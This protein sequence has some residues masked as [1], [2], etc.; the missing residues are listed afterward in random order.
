MKTKFKV[1]ILT[2]VF[3]LN[4]FIVN[5]CRELKVNRQTNTNQNRKTTAQKVSDKNS[6]HLDSKNSSKN[7]RSKLKI[8]AIKLRTKLKKE[9]LFKND[10]HELSKML[11]WDGFCEE[12]YYDKKAESNVEI[13]NPFHS[14]KKDTYLLEIPCNREGAYHMGYLFYFIDE[15]KLTSTLLSFEKFESKDINKKLLRHISYYMVG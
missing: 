12:T 3:F 10:L 5:G 14:V 7:I 15:K 6:K 4:M 8:K 11:G 1:V 2:G 13:E 9:N